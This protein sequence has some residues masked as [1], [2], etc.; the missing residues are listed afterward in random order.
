MEWVWIFLGIF[1]VGASLSWIIPSSE[2]LKKSQ[3]RMDAKINGVKVTIEKPPTWLS[4]RL[5]RFQVPVYRWPY[6]YPK[7]IIT[8]WRL[9]DR[10]AGGWIWNP[11]DLGN[12]NLVIEK[13]Q[14]CGLS[15]P[16]EV[17]GIGY[18]HSH[19]W[20]AVDDHHQDLTFGKLKACVEKLVDE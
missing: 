17:F 13:I 3:L 8:V 14:N 7:A 5:Q 19:V 12:H 2:N 20:L 18:E 11:K 1:I 9:P 10:P 15:I 16:K 4:G 6:K